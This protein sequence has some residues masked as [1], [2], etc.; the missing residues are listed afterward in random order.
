MTFFGSRINQIK[1]TKTPISNKIVVSTCYFPNYKH[2]FHRGWNNSSRNLNYINKLIENIETFAM[3][4][5][6]FTSHPE[7]WVYRVYLD[8]TILNLENN[9]H[10]IIP[11]VELKNSNY[12]TKKINQLS[13]PLRNKSN[14]NLILEIDDASTQIRY[15]MISAYNI[16]FFIGKLMK[17]YINMILE[18]KDNSYDNIEIMTYSNSELKIYLDNNVNKPISGLIETYGTLMRFHPCIDEDV[19]AV[20]MRNC[21]HNLTPLDLIIQNYWL[22][23]LPTLEYMEYVDINYDFT[24]DRQ[25]PV[26]GEWYKIFYNNSSNIKHTR[27]R[28]MRHFG[29]DRIMAGLISVK[30]N[31]RGNTHYKDVFNKLYEKMQ[32]SLSGSGNVFHLLELKTLYTYGI[33]EAVLHFIFPDLRSGSYRHKDIINPPGLKNKTFALKIINGNSSTCNKCDKKVLINQLNN[34][35]GTLS[36]SNKPITL[37]KKKSPKNKIDK[38]Q[39]TCCLNDIYIRDSGYYNL[40]YKITEGFE[41][42]RII[43]SLR[44][45]PLYKLKINTWEIPALTFT[46]VLEGIMFINKYTFALRDGTNIPRNVLRTK[47]IKQTSNYNNKMTGRNIMTETKTKTK[48]STK[49]KE[50]LTKM[51]DKHLILCNVRSKNIN[52]EIEKFI[53]GIKKAYSIDNFYPILIYPKKIQILSY[54]PLT[55]DKNKSKTI[56]FNNM[57][58]LITHKHG[59]TF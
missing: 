12:I 45:L 10:N 52:K 9:I 34:A 18:S 21:S 57:L 1:T 49:T 51:I 19:Q 6:R 30:V 28:K 24:V 40:G 14:N 46:N 23:S 35:L 31:I 22:E 5:S 15:N 37:T 29:Y 11:G 8:E 17:K 26:R 36:K 32:E 4:T 59:F 44:A 58:E 48:T 38:K 54:Y 13:K 3:K 33:D 7:K 25:V 39:S 43:A 50:K 2:Y 27:A 55:K 47:T 42:D 56:S 16:L 20:I 41:L 53:E